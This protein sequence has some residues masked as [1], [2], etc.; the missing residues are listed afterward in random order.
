M[1]FDDILLS[2]VK[3]IYSVILLNPAENSPFKTGKFNH[4]EDGERADGE[5]REEALAQ[6]FATGAFYDNIQIKL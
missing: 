5:H 3:K 4:G 1:Y 6:V 2:F